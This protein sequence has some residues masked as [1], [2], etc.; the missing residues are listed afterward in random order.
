MIS[1][2]GWPRVPGPSFGTHYKESCIHQFLVMTKSFL[3]PW[4][5]QGLQLFQ[6]W[7]FV[8]LRVMQA[9]IGWC[10]ERW[11]RGRVRR[12]KGPS[13]GLWGVW[14]LW[15]VPMW[16]IHGCLASQSPSW[17]WVASSACMNVFVI[18]GIQ[19]ECFQ[20]WWLSHLDDMPKTLWIVPKPLDVK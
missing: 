9:R 13:L 20:F 15:W 4:A 14:I 7:I 8:G 5:S 11:T 1:C 16:S 6:H 18:P 10:I 19:L 3:R 2:Q 12:S 17:G